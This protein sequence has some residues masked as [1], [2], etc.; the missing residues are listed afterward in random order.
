M[1]DKIVGIIFLPLS[2]IMF[3]NLFGITSITSIIGL[4]M[5][6]IAAI[7]LIIIQVANV[8]GAHHANE[9]VKKSYILCLAAAFPSIIYFIG[10]GTGLPETVSVSMPAIFASFIF[11][12][13]IYG[14]YF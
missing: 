11:V 4:D 13:G 1:I 5:L 12:E 7:A 14:F 9:H 6:F 3:L 2:I 8:L 10:L